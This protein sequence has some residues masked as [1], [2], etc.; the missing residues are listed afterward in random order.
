MSDDR[1]NCQFLAIVQVEHDELVRQPINRFRSECQTS[2]VSVG[3]HWY[4][5]GASGSVDADTLHLALRVA[6][7][8]QP[9]WVCL[10]IQCRVDG[11]VADC[12]HHNEFEPTQ[13][14][15]SREIRLATNQKSY[16][17]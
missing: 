5:I 11:C 9:G 17:L 4:D 13:S 16:N 10:T 14:T 2:T 1:D 15:R 12:P 7:A 6:V 8:S 3:H